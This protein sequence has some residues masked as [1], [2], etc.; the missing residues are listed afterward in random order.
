[1]SIKGLLFGYLIFCNKMDDFSALC[2]LCKCMVM[3][4]QSDLTM[5]NN[6]YTITLKQLEDNLLARLSAAGGNFLGDTALVENL[7]H[8]KKTAAE[9]EEK[10]AEAKV[11]EVSQSVWSLIPQRSTSYISCQ[12]LPKSCQDLPRSCQDF[13]LRSSKILPISCKFREN[14]RRNPRSWQDIQV[15]IQAFVEISNMK[16][17]PR[18]PRWIPRKLKSQTS[19]MKK[20]SQTAELLLMLQS[21][22]L[23]F[24]IELNS[25]S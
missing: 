1:M 17:L 5:Q 20:W 2:D 25:L 6:E 22:W 15:E 21:G 13:V 18:N 12:D 19:E 8:T 3:L 14:L 11:T 24:E 16:I 23:K 9:I 10:V 7:E 4:F